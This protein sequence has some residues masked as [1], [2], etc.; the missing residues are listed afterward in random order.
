MLVFAG[1][2]Y[3]TYARNGDW[4][5]VE[6]TGQRAVGAWWSER[7]LICLSC[8]ERGQAGIAPEQDLMAL[9]C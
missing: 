1:A 5:T 3:M 4:F 7:S 9:M 2:V 8:S 6:T